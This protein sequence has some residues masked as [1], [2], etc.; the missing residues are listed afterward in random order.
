[1]SEDQQARLVRHKET[2]EIASFCGYNY[3]GV[4]EFIALFGDGS[5][6]SEYV[7]DYEPVDGRWP[8]ER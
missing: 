3:H 1:M 2:G 6:S 7:R 8:D 5:K 4:G